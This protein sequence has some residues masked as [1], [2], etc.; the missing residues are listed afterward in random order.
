MQYDFFT[1][2]RDQ[3]LLAQVGAPQNVLVTAKEYPLFLRQVAAGVISPNYVLI[4]PGVHD[5]IE[6][7]LEYPQIGFFTPANLAALP[8]NTYYSLDYPPDMCPAK[9]DYY[10]DKSWMEAVA[11]QGDPHAV[12][13]VQSRMGDLARFKEQFQRYIRLEIRSGILG[14]GNMCRFVSPSCDEGQFACDVFAH[15]RDH[16]RENRNVKWI[17]VYGLSMWHIPTLLS[18]FGQEP[19]HLSTDS[20]KW[21]RPRSGALK[22]VIGGCNATTQADRLLCLQDYLQRLKGEAK[23]AKSQ[24]RLF[25]CEELVDLR[26]KALSRAREGQA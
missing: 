19:I 22:D 15:V 13:T 5:L 1:T 14:I 24:K 20:T 9:T 4:D 18:L 26:A 11:R 10:L 23:V 16:Y 25:T 7:S 17:H 2:R 12:I 6:C 8:P 3:P 21:T